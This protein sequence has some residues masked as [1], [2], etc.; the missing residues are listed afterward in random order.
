M[1]QIRKGKI[2]IC[3]KQYSVLNLWKFVHFSNI[4]PFW[5]VFLKSREMLYI[6]NFTIFRIR[7]KSTFAIAIEQIIL[8]ILKSEMLTFP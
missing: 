4:W 1:A 7:F 2:M 6:L 8:M 5:P 3:Q